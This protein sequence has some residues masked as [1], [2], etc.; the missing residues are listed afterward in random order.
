MD[1]FQDGK[2]IKSIKSRKYKKYRKYKKSRK[3]MKTKK[4][5]KLKKGKKSKTGGFPGNNLQIPQ[6][7]EKSLKKMVNCGP[8]VLYILN[9]INYH[10]LIEY[11]ERCIPFIGISIIDMLNILEEKIRPR[12]LLIH[13]KYKTNSPEFIPFITSYF[14]EMSRELSQPLYASVGLFI[15]LKPDGSL[16]SGHYVI[17]II[18]NRIVYV[19]DPHGSLILTDKI[20]KDKSLT[21]E[22][23][24]ET[25]ISHDDYQNDYIPLSS[26]KYASRCTDLI[27]ISENINSNFIFTSR[28]LE[29][30]VKTTPPTIEVNILPE[31]IANS[32]MVNKVKF[33]D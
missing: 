16:F 26:Y 21:N 23:S 25:N 19:I 8:L 30:V 11:D 24:T 14:N 9:I 22:S 2:S 28:I 12:C 32:Y 33:L 15:I 3:G 18:K 27:L 29:E 31:D 6:I 7:E 20:N 1:L 17:L 5:K 13:I 10:E 4:Y